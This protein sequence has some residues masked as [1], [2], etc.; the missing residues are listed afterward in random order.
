MKKYSFLS[1]LVAGLLSQGCSD[2]LDKEPLG[3]ETD[4]NYFSDSTNTVLAINA[5]YDAASYDEGNDG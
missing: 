1:L 5:V 3:R 4:T 2:F